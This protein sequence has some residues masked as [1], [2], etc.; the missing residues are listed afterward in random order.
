[1][2]RTRVFTDSIP[3]PWTRSA[4]AWRGVE[5]FA[6]VVHENLLLVG[7][8]QGLYALNLADGEIAWRMLASMG[9][10]RQE[11]AEKL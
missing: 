6:P 1:M 3:Q 9:K 10:K 7:S 11:W 4:A 5:T 8:T 2:F